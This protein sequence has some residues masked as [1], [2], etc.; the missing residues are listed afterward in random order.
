MSGARYFRWHK[1]PPLQYW[2]KDLELGY[3]LEEECQPLLKVLI[4]G[5]EVEMDVSG[6]KD[7]AMIQRLMEIDEKMTD[8][9]V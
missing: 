7:D 4:G 1:F 3:E 9:A 5:K 2:N 8:K 6:M